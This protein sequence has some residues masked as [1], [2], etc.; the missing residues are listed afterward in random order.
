MSREALNALRRRAE[1]SGL[2]TWPDSAE[3]AAEGLS[4]TMAM[5][6]LQL[7]ALNL[8]PP[9]APEEH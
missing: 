9:P 3:E 4:L 1:E 2:P 8:D 5:M 7:E 6:P